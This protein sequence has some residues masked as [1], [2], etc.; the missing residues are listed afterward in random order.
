MTIYGLDV[1]LSQFWTSPLFHIQLSCFLT[2]IQVLQEADKVA[3]YSY[4]FKNFPEFV[5]I[6]TVKGFS[7]VNEAVI[8]VFLELL[9][10]VHDPK[11][12]SNVIL[13]PLSLETNL[14][15]W[16]FLVHV[17]LKKRFILSFICDGTD[18]ILKLGVLLFCILCNSFDVS[19]FDWYK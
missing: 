1:L 12:V 9:W 4:L 2:C 13:V 16:K 15:I 11:S 8:D 5:V 7:V 19:K 10:F 17:L 6:H 14:Y 3:W 18:E